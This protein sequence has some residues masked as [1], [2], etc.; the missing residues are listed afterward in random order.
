MAQTYDN[1]GITFSMN[2]TVN[3]PLALQLAQSV[4]TKSYSYGW[5]SGTGQGQADRLWT[6][7][8]TIAAAGN[9]DIDLNGVQVDPVGTIVSLLRVKA[10]VIAS[11]AAN[12]NNLVV[13]AAAA[14]G[15]ISWVGAS[16]HTV[17][18]RPG[19]LL[20]LVAP[21]LT[22]YAVTAATA[23]ILRVTNGAGGTSVTY[24][25]LIVGASA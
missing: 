15:F 11:N 5:T 13:G 7:T 25:I 22:A 14:N 8:R 23:D 9:D 16:T 10:L 17:T 20:A 19:G 4:L 3:N 2:G 1:Q 18:V 12:V 6:A 21:D 24:D